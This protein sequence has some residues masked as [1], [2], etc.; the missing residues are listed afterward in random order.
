MSA[1]K[2]PALARTG[3]PT[4]AYWRARAD[5]SRQCAASMV[6]DEVREALVNIAIMYDALADRAARREVRARRETPG[7]ST[8]SNAARSA[9]Q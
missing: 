3:L 9:K 4:E 2:S 6:T 7:S 5:R 8:A 1:Q